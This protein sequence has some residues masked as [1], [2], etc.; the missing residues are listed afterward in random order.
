MKRILLKAFCLLAVLSLS[1]VFQAG[2]QTKKKLGIADKYSKNVKLR[3]KD[4]RKKNKVCVVFAHGFGGSGKGHVR[5]YVNAGMFPNC[6]IVSCEFPDSPR[7]KGNNGKVNIS[8]TY[9]GQGKEQEVLQETFEEVQ[10]KYKILLAGVS[11]GAIAVL[12]SDLKDD[13]VGIFVESPAATLEDVAQNYCKQYGFGWI[14][15]LGK[16]VHEWV[17]P[18]IFNSYDPKGAKPLDYAKD[19]PHTVPVFISYVKNDHLIPAASSVALAEELVKAG[20]PQVYLY[21]SEVGQ[22]GS[23]FNQKYADVTHAFLKLCGAC[24]SKNKDYNC[25]DGYK[26]LAACKIDSLEQVEAIKKEAEWLN[27]KNYLG[28]NLAVLSGIVTCCT[29]LARKAWSFIES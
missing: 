11:R 20:H 1:F 26:L 17:F 14:P 10:R 15:S 12:N 27:W 8:K 19:I 9:F 3:M 18:W 24:N 21:G 28:R 13:A 25:S 7:V 29:F 4:L 22:H 6:K 5:Q 16:L 23:M 2:T